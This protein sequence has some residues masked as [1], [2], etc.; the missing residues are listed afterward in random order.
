M[1]SKIINLLKSTDYNSFLLGVEMLKQLDISTLYQICKKLD[2]RISNSF[3]TS[4]PA[5]IVINCYNYNLT[6]YNRLTIGHSYKLNKVKHF[7]LYTLLS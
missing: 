1:K 5:S 2:Y 6:V 3:N 4:N 7:I